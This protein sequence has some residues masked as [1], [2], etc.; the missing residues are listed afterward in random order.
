MS[1]YLGSKLKVIKKLGILP[2]FSKKYLKNP[3]FKTVI[4]QDSSIKD[5]YKVNLIEK[6]KL[7]FNYLITE[8]QLLNY[9][10]KAK[11]KSGATGTLLLQL[12]ESRLDNIVFRLGFS[13]TILAARQYINHR[14]ILVNNQLV[15]YAN[16]H[17]NI[18]DIIS[19]KSNLKSQKLITKVLN[20]KLQEQKLFLTR[21]N[22]INLFTNYF[23]D[24]LPS[25]LSLDSVTLTGRVNSVINPLLSLLHIN[26]L[27][28]LEYYSRK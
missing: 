4:V 17:C 8:K 20:T 3:N 23:T 12:L 7:R 24:K 18:N 16:Y 14:H 11:K 10:L 21:I 19:I 5:D 2:G 15:T 6:Q 27:K 13:P 9:Y 1:K 25:F 28:V 22:T 26:E